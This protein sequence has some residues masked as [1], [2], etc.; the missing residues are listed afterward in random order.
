MCHQIFCGPVF[1][2]IYN[3]N[4]VPS[5]CFVQGSRFTRIH[6]RVDFKLVSIHKMTVFT[7]TRTFTEILMQS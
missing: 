5:G 3:C 2:E 6:T 7:F 1:K 4:Y